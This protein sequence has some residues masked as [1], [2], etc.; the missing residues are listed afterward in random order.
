MW[1]VGD[2]DEGSGRSGGGL[3]EAEAEAEAWLPARLA[4]SPYLFKAI[5]PSSSQQ[6]KQQR[7]Q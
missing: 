4:S 7:I 3:V 6:R 5:Q 2:E 1:L